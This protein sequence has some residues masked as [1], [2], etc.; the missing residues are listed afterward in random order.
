MSK[1]IMGGTKRGG[2]MCRGCRNWGKDK[3][4]NEARGEGEL[5]RGGGGGGAENDEWEGGRSLVVCLVKKR[6]KKKN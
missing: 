2:E 1:S 4:R 6:R 5:Y 3:R